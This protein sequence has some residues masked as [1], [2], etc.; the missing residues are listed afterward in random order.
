MVNSLN[1]LFADAQ[2][3]GMSVQSVGIMVNN[4]NPLTTAGAQGLSVD[5]LSGD[6]VT[7]Y[8]RVL[9][10]TGSM[11]RFQGVVIDAGNRQI[12]ALMGSKAGDSILMST[13][14]FNETSDLLHS[15]LPLGTVQRLDGNNYDPD[16]MTALYD[17]VLNAITSAVAYAQ[18]LRNAGIRVKIVIVIV[19]D[20][21]DNASKATVASVR[22]V[23]EDLLKQEIYTVAMVAFGTDGKKIATQMGIPAENVL[24]G[25]ADEH[26]IRIAFGTTSASVIRASQTVIGGASGSFFS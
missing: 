16:G 13:W 5:D 7:L 24:E 23:I 15:Y 2:D 9:D 18:N 4:L 21:E 25:D 10:R 19:S 3:D 6:E 14:T 11:K 12:D 17:A 26:S 8:A 1:G 22:T 20:G